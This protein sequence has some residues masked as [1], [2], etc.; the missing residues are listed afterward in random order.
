VILLVSEGDSGGDGMIDFKS[1]ERKTYDRNGKLTL[2]IS[3]RDFEGDGIIDFKATENKTYDRRGNL[4]LSVSEN[5]FNADGKIDS[6]F[7]EINTYNRQGKLTNSISESSTNGVTNSR[8]TNTNT[9]DKRGNLVRSV[10][11]NDFNADG[12]IDERKTTSATYD[13]RD[14]L[15]GITIVGKNPDKSDRITNY[16]ADNTGG[17]GNDLLL[18][19][20]NADV[21]KGGGGADIF[22]L[23][24][25]SGSDTIT[26]FQKGTDLIG[27]AQ[28]VSFA[29]LSFNKNQILLAGQTIATL[30]GV[31]TSTLTAS[32]FLNI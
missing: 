14:K 8:S 30:T 22:G 32:D 10:S 19:T 13:S 31:Q 9:Y 11:E 26:D 18:G 12:T 5:D 28:G 7:T 29:Q 6:V 2:S 17:N 27:L 3:E 24:A 21:L 4:V 23:N 16:K 1:I 15:C 20:E 25:K